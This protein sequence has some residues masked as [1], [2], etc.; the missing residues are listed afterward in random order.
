MKKQLHYKVEGIMDTRQKLLECFANMGIIID[1]QEDE[2][3]LKEYILD[4]IQ[5]ITVIVEIERMFSIEFPDEL[6]LYSVFDSLTGLISLIDSLL[7]NNNEVNID[8]KQL[9]V[10]GEE[11]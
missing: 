3:D 8:Q 6:L 10:G 7:A 1:A 5:F 2:V 11:G 9:L 4:S